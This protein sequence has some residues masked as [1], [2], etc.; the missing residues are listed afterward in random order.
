[1]GGKCPYSC[2]FVECCF[3]RARG[4]PVQ[5]PSS[6]FSVHF[7]SVYVVHPYSRIDTIAAWKKLYFILLDKSDF[8]LI[9]DQSIAVH[10][11]VSCI[12]MSFS[13]DEMLLPRYPNLSTDLRETPFFFL[14]K[15]M[16]TVLSVITWM[17]MRP[18]ACS[19]LCGRDSV[20]VGVFA[21]SARSSA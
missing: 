16:Y 18:A 11:F 1:M 19:R 8:H 13:V 20:W 14:L 6:F 12:L 3:N 21:R 15:H 2:C 5:L 9:N 17:P 4:I 10:A 7:V